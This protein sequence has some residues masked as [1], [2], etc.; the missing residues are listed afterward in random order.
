MRNQ[1]FSGWARTAARYSAI[2][3]STPPLGPQGAAEQA[4]ELAGALALLE[5]EAVAVL[6]D[7]LVQPALL[8]QGIGEQQASI[9]APWSEVPGLEPDVL[10][11]LGDGLV[12]PA[13][14]PQGV[15]Q[16]VVSPGELGLDSDGLAEL[17]DGLVL[18][19]LLQQGVAQL[20]MIPPFAR[21]EMDGG[22]EVANGAI[23]I[24]HLPQSHA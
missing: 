10:A 14:V 12:Q 23:Q 8:H 11:V 22:L 24:S 13:H 4:K 18:P 3:S 15:A 2:S 21:V 5:S 1:A 17:G 20:H 9:E 7:G 16:L 6:G 19:A